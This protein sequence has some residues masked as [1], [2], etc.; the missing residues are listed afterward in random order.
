MFW[1]LEITIYTSAILAFLYA[2]FLVTL[3]CF[4]FNVHNFEQT[5]DTMK[6]YEGLKPTFILAVIGTSQDGQVTR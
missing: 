2:C 6:P 1:A 4:T 3:V 5:S